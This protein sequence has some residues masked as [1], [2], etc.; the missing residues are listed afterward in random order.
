MKS[1]MRRRVGFWTLRLPPVVEL[2]LSSSLLLLFRAAPDDIW[3]RTYYTREM[4]QNGKFSFLSNFIFPESEGKEKKKMRER[5][6]GKPSVV[7]SCVETRNAPKLKLQRNE[8]NCVYMICDMCL[9][10]AFGVGV[11]VWVCVGSFFF[12]IY[13]VTQ[14]LPLTNVGTLLGYFFLLT[15]LLNPIFFKKKNT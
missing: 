1:A 11:G 15:V 6:R 13:S 10:S 12:S 3:P 14:S 9:R 2:E 5:K 8:C 4:S 7:L